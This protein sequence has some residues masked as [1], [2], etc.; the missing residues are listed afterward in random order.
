MKN[1]INESSSYYFTPREIFDALMSSKK[2]MTT[3]ILVELARDRG[4]IVSSDDTREDII[5][6]LSSFVYDY[7]DLNVLVEYITPSHKKEKLKT[8]QLDNL[9]DIND[10]VKASKDI[11]NNQDDTTR[12]TATKDVKDPNKTIIKI[13]WEDIDLG[14]TRLRQKVPKESTVEFVEENGV[15]K[16]SKV[17]NEKV[18][19]VL[20]SIISKVSKKINIDIKEEKINLHG[21][22]FEE[23]TQYFTK[24]INSIDNCTLSDVVKVS[25]N[26]EDGFD[27]E[28]DMI[29]VI[30][31]ASFKGNGLLHTDEY[32]KLKE[33]EYFITSILWQSVENR[34]NGDK[35]EFEASLVISKECEELTFSP[36]V[37]FRSNGNGGYTKSRRP[38]KEEELSQYTKILE[39]QAFSIYKGIIDNKE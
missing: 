6:Y 32:Q 2:T 18:D 14:K 28:E 10:L 26:K 24:L 19:E 30:T 5:K 7:Y 11:S 38:L 36:K 31:N 9:I 39:K 15:I 35:I 13:E 1:N 37:I 4:V 22:S 27:E 12:V 8:T 17:S 20:Q 33:R 21:F 23:K 25:V 34:Q 29:E 3:S 16:V